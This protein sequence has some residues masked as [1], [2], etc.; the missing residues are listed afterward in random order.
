MTHT[1]IP[2]TE[3]ERA[4]P[5]RARYYLFLVR[6]CLALSFGM[7]VLVAGSGISR[8]AT[9]AGL[10]ALG[11]GAVTLRWVG[12]H[13]S[14][15]DRLLAL[16]VA[17]VW[18]AVALSLLFH[19]T[20]GTLIGE[21]TLLDLLG[22]V[23]VATGV[24]RMSGRFHDDPF[25]GDHPRARYRYVLGPLDV[26]LGIVVILAEAHTSTGIRI[27]FGC[28]GLVSGTFLLVDAMMLRRGL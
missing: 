28:W 27:A 5:P 12:A 24:L 4:P 11:A 16:L 15:V 18:I 19:D 20:V 13:R 26:V 6:A 14:K 3:A 9:F 1:D 2:S 17:V 21:A 8:L 22:A 10:N 23:S 25:A 7:A